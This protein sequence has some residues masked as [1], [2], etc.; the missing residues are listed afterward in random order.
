[1]LLRRQQL[2]TYEYTWAFF[3]F[4]SLFFVPPIAVVIG[5]QGGL[6]Q[7][8]GTFE[9]RK[10]SVPRNMTAYGHEERLETCKFCGPWLVRA[11]RCE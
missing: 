7:R 8:A 1:M 5:T 9:W 3:F 10:I 2:A 6:A 11:Q 4:S